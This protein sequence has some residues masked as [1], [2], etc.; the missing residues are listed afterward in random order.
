L[1]DF[2]DAAS[3]LADV[4]VVERKGPYADAAEREVG[5][6]RRAD[7]ELYSRR[8]GLLPRGNETEFC[9]AVSV[10][11]LKKQRGLLR[12][13]LP[14]AGRCVNRRRPSD[15]DRGGL[16]RWP[17]EAAEQGVIGD[18]GSRRSGAESAIAAARKS[19]SVWRR[20]LPHGFLGRGCLE[21]PEGGEEPIRVRSPD[22]DVLALISEV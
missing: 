12:R 1:R 16:R 13:G 5:R 6:T 2:V 20:S 4:A 15:R 14:D 10:C 22:G 7:G 11:N 19:L 18:G 17:S 9:C 8:K 21:E 3:T